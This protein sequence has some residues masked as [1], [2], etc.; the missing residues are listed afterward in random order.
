M[1]LGPGTGRRLFVQVLQAG[2]FSSKTDEVRLISLELEQVEVFV[3]W[4]RLFS[5]TLRSRP[6]RSLDL[7]RK[8]TEM[9]SDGI[10]PTEMY[11][12]HMYSDGIRCITW[13]SDGILCITW[14]SDGI[15]ILWTFKRITKCIKM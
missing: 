7:A 11:G 5:A 3:C 2:L 10:H 4:K 14:Y 15:L 6:K 9:G 8:R 13:Y 1:G 12:V